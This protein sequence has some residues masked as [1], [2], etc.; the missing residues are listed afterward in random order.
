MWPDGNFQE[1]NLQ[2]LRGQSFFEHGVSPV[3]FNYEINALGGWHGKEAGG[4]RQDGRGGLG[5]QGTLGL[6]WPTNWDWKAFPSVGLRKTM[7][8]N[9]L[10]LPF[11]VTAEPLTLLKNLS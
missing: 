8:K 2:R 9:D 11:G 1:C 3:F 6:I 4:C 10:H 5:S 7:E